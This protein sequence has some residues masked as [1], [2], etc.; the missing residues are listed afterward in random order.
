MSPTSRTDTSPLQAPR[1]L[2][3]AMKAV[4]MWDAHHGQGQGPGDTALGRLREDIK[5]KASVLQPPQPPPLPLREAIPPAVALPCLA[6]C[7]VAFNPSAGMYAPPLCTQGQQKVPDGGGG[8]ASEGAHEASSANR[9]L[10]LAPDLRAQRGKARGGK[11]QQRQRVGGGQ[12]ALTLRDGGEVQQGDALDTLKTHTGTCSP[13]GFRSL[14]ETPEHSSGTSPRS[15]LCRGC[16]GEGEEEAEKKRRERHNDNSPW[17]KKH[18]RKTPLVRERSS[19]DLILPQQPPVPAASSE[20]LAMAL[21]PAPALGQGTALPYGQAVVEAPATGSVCKCS[22]VSSTV[23]SGPAHNPN[24]NPNPSPD[25]GPSPSRSPAVLTFL[26][27]ERAQTLPVCTSQGQ[28]Q[29]AVVGKALKAEAKALYGSTGRGVDVECG[30]GRE[31][32][33]G[34]GM[35][36]GRHK[37]VLSRSLTDV[38]KLSLLR[39]TEERQRRVEVRYG[40]FP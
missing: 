9:T 15:P 26:E 8:V 33:K 36:R 2:L 11:R 22:T 16:G 39:E 10:P 21:T 28:E 3:V 24:P 1:G 4:A 30:R 6:G 29:G 25:L 7:G 12:V 17:A 13:S 18:R 27:C 19:E 14:K 40:A 31:R 37:G 35:R 23:V 38:D 34:M 32:G 5:R 20:A